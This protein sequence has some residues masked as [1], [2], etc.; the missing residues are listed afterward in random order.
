MIKRSNEEIQQLATLLLE[1]LQAPVLRT[2][3]KQAVQAGLQQA[4]KCVCAQH[5]DYSEIEKNLPAPKFTVQARAIAVMAG[6]W[7]NGEETDW[8]R[9]V[10][11]LLRAPAK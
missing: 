9:F 8:Q 1:T 10:G 5:T 3:A 2:P 4:W 11:N 7:L 6:D